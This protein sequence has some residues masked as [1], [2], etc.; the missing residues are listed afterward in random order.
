VTDRIIKA[1]Y[2]ADGGYNYS[3]WRE[4]ALPALGEYGNRTQPMRRLGRARSFTLETECT[5]PLVVDIIEAVASYEVS[6]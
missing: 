5:S 2:S 6:A 4:L 3:N 1:R